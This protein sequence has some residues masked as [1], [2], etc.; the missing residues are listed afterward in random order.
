MKLIIG[1]GNPDKE[2]QWT[3][4]NFGWLALD[5]LATK[6]ELKWHKHKIS[7]ADVAEFRLN[8]EKIVL[9]KPLTFMNNSGLA[10]AALKQ[11]YKV[12]VKDVVVVYDELALDFGQIRIS[13]NR[14]AGGHNGVESII[15]NIKSKEFARVRL[16]I[17]PQLGVAEKFVL[18]K[19]SSEEKKKLPE[20]IDTAYLALETILKEGVDKAANQYN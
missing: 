5:N 2:Y 13:Q 4:H 18:H 16:G 7:Q 8:K 20:I 1:L 17:G 11:F 14:S 3:R 9:A 12:S 15:Q 10:V 6:Y 19:F